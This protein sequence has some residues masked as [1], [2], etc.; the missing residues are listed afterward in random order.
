VELLQ[1]LL[2]L[3]SIEFNEMEIEVAFK[4]QK[5]KVTRLELMGQQLHGTLSGTIT[6]NDKIA[7]SSLHLSGTIEPF[8]AFFKSTPGTI[9][10]VKFFKQRLKKGT[11]SFVIHGTLGQPRIEFT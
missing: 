4:K 11:L 9:D 5:I 10:T 2:T 3:T 8:A 7:K 6:L 1:P